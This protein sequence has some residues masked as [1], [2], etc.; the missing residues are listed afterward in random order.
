MTEYNVIITDQANADLRNIYEYIAFELLSPG[1]AASQLDRLES[2]I[3]NLNSFPE[4]YR[5]YQKEP[6]Y[7]R[8]MRIMPVDNYVVLFIPDNA[9]A[10]VTVNRVMYAGR[11]IDAQM[12]QYVMPDK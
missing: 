4:K 9:T 8:G 2:H 7:S 1:N 5:L 3:L 6:W 11:D 12:D 10:T